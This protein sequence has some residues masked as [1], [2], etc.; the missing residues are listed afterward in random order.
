MSKI[1]IAPVILAHLRTLRDYR[2][3]NRVSYSDLFVFFI[4]PIIAA[5]LLISI[6]FGYRV[7]AVSAFLN[8]FSV[9]TGLLL[10]LLVLVFTLASAAAPMNMD[11]QKR[12]V[13]LTEIFANVCFCVLIAISVVCTALVSLSYMRSS[14]GAV[15]G[16]AATFLLT[17]LTSNF[18]LTLLMIIK[19]MFVL[20]NKEIEK[21]QSRKAA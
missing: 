4:I 14:S 1:N 5:A 12:K 11:I 13:L 9:L 20:L 8:A 3:G 19:R 7:D 15:T 10:N 21:G 2:F 18:V 16:R 17:L 6:G